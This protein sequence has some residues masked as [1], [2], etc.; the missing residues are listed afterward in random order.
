[1][2][3]VFKLP[4]SIFCRNIDPGRNLQLY[5]MRTVRFLAALFFTAAFAQSQA[6]TITI[7]QPNGAEILY[8][9]QQYTVSWNTGGSVSD[10]YDIDYSLDGGTIWASVTTNYFSPSHQYLWTVPNV[11]SGTVLVRVRDAQNGTIVDQSNAF[12]TINVPITVT[13]PNGGETL[14]PFTNHTITW[15]AQGTSNTYNISY[16]TNNGSIWNTIASN[17]N[18]PGATYNWSVPN[19]PST[20]CLVRVTDYVTGCM[21][22]R[23]NSTFTIQPLSPLMTYPN[24]GEVL[25]VGQAINITWNQNTFYNTVRLEYSTDGGSTWTTIAAST[26]NDG[27]QSWTVPYLPLNQAYTQCLVR[28]SDSSNPLL[29]DVS[30]VTFTVAKPLTLIAPNGGETLTGCGT[31]NINSTMNIQGLNSDWS[32]FYSTNNGTSWTAIVTGNSSPSYNWNVPNTVNSAQMLVRVLHNTYTQYADTS[33]AVFSITPSNDITLTAPNGGQ[34]LTPGQTYLISWTNTANVSGLYEIRYSSSAG[35]GTIASNITGNNHL[36]TVPNVPATD[37][38]ITVYDYNNSCKNDRSDANFTVLPMAPLVTYPNGGESFIV[39]QSI[40]IT[41]NTQTYYSPTVRIEYSSDNGT[42][43]NIITTSTTND[44]SQNWTIPIVPLNQAYTQWLVKV[45]E[46]ANPLRSDVSNT[47]FNTYKPLTLTAPNGGESLS[48]CAGFTLTSLPYIDGTWSFSYSTNNG[49]SWTSITSTSSAS[50]NWTVPNNISTTQGLVRVM[51]NTYPQFGDT[52]N[53]NFSINSNSEITVVNPNGGQSLTPGQTYLITW[54]NTPNVSGVYEISYSSSAGSGSIAS[55]VTGNSYL[56]TVPNVPA[57][58][59]RITVYDYNNSCKND[60]SD[61]DFTVLPLAPLVTYPNGGENFQ[62][63]QSFNITWNTQTYYSSTVRIEYSSDN[64]TTWNTITTSTTNDGSQNWTVPIV[65]LNQ[66]YTQWLVKVSETVNL[67][68]NDVSNANFNTYKPLTLTAPNGGESLSGC[69][70]FTLTSLPYVDGTWTYS[71]STNNGTS[72][73]YII[74]T[75][76]ASHNWTVPNNISTTQGLVRVMHNT[77]PQFGDTSNANFSINSNSEITVVNPN[78]GQ[79]LTPGQTYLITWTNTPNVSGVYEISYSSSAGSGSIA[80]NVTGNSYLWTVPNLPANNYR[81]TVSDYNNGCKND[82]SDADFTVLPLAPLVTYPNGGENFQVGQSFNI[83]WNTQT[84]YSSTVRIEYSSDNGTTWNTIT[85]STTNDGSQ[86]WTIPIVPLNQAYTQWLIKVSETSNLLRTDV[87]NANFNTYKPLTLTAPNGADTLNGCSTYQ[88]SSIPYI[89]GT[90]SFSYSTNNGASWTSITSTG[91]ANYTWTVPNNISTTQGLVRVMHNTYPQYGDTSNMNFVIQPKNFITVLAPNG[92]EI[93]PAQTAYMI[94]WANSSGVSG[95]YQLNYSSSSGSGTIASNITGNNYLWT[96]PNLP[97]TNYTITVTDQQNACKTDQS[98]AP[99]TIT[100]LSAVMTAPNGG[101]VIYYGESKTITW[102]QNTYYTDVRIDYST[103]N[104]TTWILL[105]NNQANDGTYTWTNTTANIYSTQCLIKVSSVSNLSHSDVS[106]ANFTVK[107]A[108]TVLTP[109]GGQ[110]LGGCT[111][112]SVTFDRSPAYNAYTIEYS[113]NGGSSWTSM[114]SSFTASGNP[115]TYN[116]TLPNNPSTQGLV[117]VT[118]NSLGTGYADVNNNPF[119]VI[120]PVTIIQPNYGGTMQIGSSYTIQWQSDGI[121]NFYDI[122]YSTDGGSTWV[123]IATN[124]ATSTNTYNW[125]VPNAPSGNCVIRVRDAINTCKEDVSDVP[126]TISSSAPLITLNTPNGQNTLTGCGNYTISW[127]SSTAFTSFNLDYSTNGGSSWNNITTNYTGGN[128]YNWIAPNISSGLVLVRVQS[129]TNNGVFDQ[130][131]ALL[132]IQQG[133]LTATPPA[134]TTICSGQQVQLNVTGSAGSYVWSPP[135]GLS[136][137]NIANPVATPSVTTVYHVTSS[138]G[139][140]VLSDSVRI[141]VNTNASVVAGVTIIASPN[142]T[143]CSSGNISFTAVPVNGG[144]TPAYQWKINGAGSGTNSSTFAPSSLNSGDVVS[145]VMTSALNC[146]SGN[147]ATSNSVPVTIVPVQTPSVT[148]AVN[149]GNIVCQGDNVT[150]T[151]T[152]V[153]GGSSPSYQWKVNGSNAGTNSPVFSTTTLNQGDVVTVTLTS[154]ASCLSSA[155]ATSSPVT[156]TVNSAPVQPGTVSGNT[157]LCSGNTSS[158]SI[159]PLSGATSYIWTLP[160]GWTGTSSSNSI[161]ATAGNN[162]GNVTVSAQNSCGTSLPS[163][164][165]VSVNS[166]PTLP[167]AGADQQICGSSATLNANDPLVG[168]GTWS[169]LNGTGTFGNAAVHNTTVSG[170]SAGVNTFTWSVSNGSCAPVTDTVRITRSLPPSVASAGNDTSICTGTSS[171]TLHANLPSSGTGH[172]TV[173][174]GNVNVISPNNPSSVLSNPGTGVHVLEWAITSGN[175]TASTDQVTITVTNPPNVN[176]SASSTIT[177]QG[178]PVTLTAGG[179]SVYTW[180][181]GNLSG[182]VVNVS[183]INTTT[184]TV[185]GTDVSGCTGTGTIMINVDPAS[186]INV[187]ASD[188]D[189]CNGDAVTLSATG[190]TNFTWQPGNISG[191]SIVVS[192]STTTTYTVSGINNGCNG[193]A[194]ITITVHALPPLNVNA[195]SNPVCSGTTIN[196]AVTGA[197]TYTWQPGNMS[198]SNVTV[199]PSATTIYSITGTSVNGCSSTATYTV[200]V[201]PAAN[202]IASATSTTL[203]TGDSSTLSATGGSTYLWQPGNLTGSTITVSPSASATY[204]VTGT[205]VNG[206]TGASVVSL[207]VGTTPNLTVNATSSS[208]CAGISTTLT[209]NGGTGYTWQPGNI[210]GASI[211]VSPLSTTTYTVSTTNGSCVATR[212]IT[213]TVNQPPVFTVNATSGTICAG[214]NTTLSASGTNSYTWQPGNIS[215]SIITVSPSATT[216]YS[217]TGTDLNGCSSTVNYLVQVNALPPITS[218]ASNGSIC[219]GDSSTLSAYG[220]SSYIWQPGNISGSQIVV[221][222]LS[223]TTYTVTGNG[224]SGCSFTSTVAVTVHAAPPITAGASGTVVCQGAPATLTATGGSTYSWMPGNLSGNNISVAPSATTTYTVTGTD[225]NGCTASQPVTITVLPVPPVDLIASNTT[226]CQGTGTTLNATG[227]NTYTWQ[228]GNLSGPSV[229]V[230]PSVT[231]TYLVTGVHA[232]GCSNTDTLTI[233][234]NAPANIQATASAQQICSGTGTTLSATGGGSYTWQPGNLSGSSITVVPGATTTYTVTGTNATGCT[235]TGNVL[236]IVNTPAPVTASGSTTICT[237]DSAQLSASGSSTYTW[238]PGNISGSSINV[239]PAGT[240]VYTVTGTDVNGC[241]STAMATVTVTSQLLVSAGS[242]AGSVCAGNSVTLNGTG[243]TNYTWQPGNI[244][245]SSPVVTPGASTTYTVTGT[246]GSCSST[247]TISI[248]VHNLPPVSATASNQA[249]CEGGPVTLSGTGAANYNWQ[250]VNLSGASITL[251]PAATTSYTVTGTDVNGC[252]STSQITVSVL[253]APNVSIN[254][255]AN[256]I[257]EGDSASLSA[258]GAATYTWEPGSLT[259]ASVT[260]DPSATT[261]YQVTGTDASGCTATATHTIL[262]NALP[263]VTFA[264]VADPCVSDGAFLLTEG[265]PSGGSYSGA[266]VTGGAFDPGTGIGSY[267]I[268]YIYTDGNGCTDS[269]IQNI[270]VIACL[271]IDNEEEASVNMY[272]NPTRD[273]VYIEVNGNTTIERIELIDDYGHT[274]SLDQVGSQEISSYLHSLDLT[275]LSDGMYHI[276]IHTAKGIIVK[277]IVKISD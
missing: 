2:Q 90:W 170:L 210:S 205:D 199:S 114:T 178:N 201:N 70:G 48:G 21:T 108:V 127:S 98:N 221:S 44:G 197:G 244:T 184:Y 107:P 207:S 239:S 68:R 266:G 142:D 203:C 262:V 96:T 158:Y 115:A 173:V 97:A 245:G 192:P 215:G 23:S 51:H 49:A 181:P 50:H 116:W 263:L 248:T 233:H 41:W 109:N 251:N 166:A 160:G 86:N 136:A 76:S 237:G 220:G 123:T 11:A 93:I 60:R 57:T 36:W 269:T 219:P 225:N 148:V 260:V 39:G 119:T 28:V 56:W 238:Q 252:T 195:S 135:A 1:M 154:S 183:P 52:S 196:M 6:Q 190:G 69:A 31:F 94:S 59:Y 15:N 67:L 7:T 3:D 145:V 54:T 64:G 10:Y 229:T 27:S 26:T 12:F 131:D 217:V 122:F 256:E 259:G 19:T 133:S 188:L 151:A 99:F 268:T 30:N 47:T 193:S 274:I 34:A 125:T 112:T 101:E 140:C 194:S 103:D 161:I 4:L 155:A 231:T 22:D 17:V 5:P 111:V 89:D 24:G 104:G 157:T 275:M 149:P 79:S 255:S 13:S 66:A 141:I 159:A 172:W 106:N 65:P 100:P 113:S 212:T 18:A 74:S 276:R 118:P 29:N 216:T 175:C 83:T 32:I 55:N 143:I 120:K 33:N 234:V 146:V 267:T 40:N 235:G 179:A 174:S 126:F 191:S 182:N 270:S 82:R 105:S 156:M 206:C 14:T 240:T 43:W 162:G 271:G 273:H 147:P 189:I 78:G 211:T 247:A 42:T 227:G 177:C 213:I 128:T 152:P 277:R 180:Q 261:Q 77:Y 243:A 163:A 129:Y 258:T 80:S 214:D 46:T 249:I 25:N 226:I 53:A 81:I 253:P 209:A 153:N 58:D 257:C 85:T 37:Y 223:T 144:T 200:Q 16:S 102:N 84:Y 139:S 165:T 224:S 124:Y 87:S 121:S 236:V 62:V 202:V 9:C 242:S 92:G 218:F 264:P 167:D 35:S 134:D 132:S 63:G 176:T 186:V 117:R 8:V 138:N 246:S 45:S 171:I 88:L 265:I 185:T 72:W 91:S 272:P 164:I 38:R 61:A 110:N 232:N 241:T 169:V 150:F 20:N 137:T 208:V 75:G 222:P 130:S 250:P 95:A 168:T 254:S 187:S 198:G 204:S 228:P 71:Y 73:T 230:S